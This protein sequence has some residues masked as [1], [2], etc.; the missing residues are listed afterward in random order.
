VNTKLLFLF[1]SVFFFGSSFGQAIHSSDCDLREMN[2]AWIKKY[3]KAA[4]MDDQLVQ[5]KDKIHE[6]S[7]FLSNAEASITPG[8]STDRKLCG[9]PIQFGLIYS[10]TKWLVLDLNENPDV[11]LLIEA[12][13]VDNVDRI[14]LYEYE[15]NKRNTFE[16]EA[17]SRITIYTSDKEIRKMIRKL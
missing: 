11:E 8:T 5:I 6:D 17:C 10:K 4:T 16:Q 13:N 14:T 12:L 1:L 7:K 15:E 2:K 3:K 9:C